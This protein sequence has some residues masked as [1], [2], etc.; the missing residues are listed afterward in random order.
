MGLDS[1]GAYTVNVNEKRW[2]DID[3]T[4]VVNP[5]FDIVIAADVVYIEEHVKG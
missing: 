4:N 1:K 2:L 3:K 5:P